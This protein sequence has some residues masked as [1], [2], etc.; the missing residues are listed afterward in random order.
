MFF[1]SEVKEFSKAF[2]RPTSSHDHY[3]EISAK[4]SKTLKKKKK[5]RFK[6]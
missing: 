5:L 6:Y 2:H 1:E 3:Y 4:S